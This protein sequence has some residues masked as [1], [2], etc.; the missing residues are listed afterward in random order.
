M[1]DAH[2]HCL[3]CSKDTDITEGFFMLRDDLWRRLVRR[4]Y[5]GG[6]LCLDCVQRRLGRELHHGDFAN[7]PVNQQQAGKCPALARRLATPS[8][9][10][11]FDHH[12]RMRR[13][14]VTS[15]SALKIAKKWRR[16]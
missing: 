12:W 5:R 13:S 7:V 3:D 9:H 4:P 11:A 15:A 16:R 8:P 2:W 10:P 14:Q 6:M 1:G